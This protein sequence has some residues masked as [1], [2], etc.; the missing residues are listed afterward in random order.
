MKTKQ[1]ITTLIILIVGIAIGKFA[2]SGSENLLKND[3]H[4]NETAVEHWTCSMHP[5]ID[6]PEPGKCPICGMDLIPKTENDE[7]LSVNSFKMTKNA[8]ALANIQT[9]T[10]GEANAV[11]DSGNSLKLSGTIQENDKKSAVQTAHFGGRIEKLYYKSEGEFV[12]QGSLIASLYSPEL[13]TAQNEFIQALEIKNEQPELYKAVRNKLKNWKISEKQ[14]LQIERNKKVITNFRMYANVSGYITKILVEEGNHVKEGTPIF[15]V[16]NLST[17]WA[18]LDVYEKDIPKIKKGMQVKLKFNSFPNEIY[19]GKIDFIDP[20]LDT[21]TRTTVARVTLKNIKNKFKPGMIV[22]GEV[23]PLKPS[24]K[25]TGKAITIPKTAVLWTGKRSVVYVKTSKDESV[26]EMREVELGQ[27]NKDTYQVLSGLN[28]GD[29]I[30]VNGTFTVDAT[31][32]LLG[33]QSMMNREEE[34]NPILDKKRVKTERLNVNKTFQKQITSVIETYLQLKDAFVKSDVNL[35]QKQATS[36]LNEIKKVDM[37]LLKNP[38][39]H[40][41]WMP[42]KKKITASLKSIS[43]SG[44]LEQQRKD[45]IDLSN[46]IIVLAKAFG[47]DK[48]L[49]VEHCPMANNNKG[50]DWISTEKEIKNP[51]FGEQMLSCGSVEETI[52]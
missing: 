12:K 48:T 25:S 38:K 19:K 40:E 14:I 11:S 6:M 52:K 13:V 27:E 21:K 9:Q 37:S 51:Y 46:Q 35:I 1:V 49:Y 44:D 50:A 33:K 34:Q 41:I 23:I 45:F 20:L 22:T 10:V 26:F 7:S 39:G 8:M 30:V 43:V 32:Q 5:Q 47:S 16:S 3:S 24:Q 36:V 31:A 15:K 4:K 2:F 29:E 17:V 28:A 42:S 18:V